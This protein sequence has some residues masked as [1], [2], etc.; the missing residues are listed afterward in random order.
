MAKPKIFV[1]RDQPGP[2]LT[3]LGNLY[4]VT[5]NPED[6][7]VSKEELIAAVKEVDGIIACVG[8]R[9]DGEVMDA[10]GGFLK[11][12][13][14]AIVGFDNVDLK[15]ATERGIYVTN[16]PGVL[17]E[18]VADLAF[19]L[20]LT[21]SRRIAEAD[22]FIRTGRW[23]GWGPKQFLGFDVHGKTLGILGLG[24]IG[25]AVAKRAKGFDM[26][27]LYFDVFRNTEMEK[28]LGLHFVPLNEVLSRSDFVSV[29]VPLIP[30]TKHMIST[31][32]LDL[33]K[34]SAFLINSSRG[35]VV[36]EK[37]LITAL[38]AGKIC[39]AGLDVWDPEPPSV[40][41]PLLTM[42]NVVTLPHIASASVETRTQMIEMAIDNLKAILNGRIPPNLVNKE[43]ISVRPLKVS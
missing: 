21:L 30:Q 40:D 12:V 9:I 24:R 31:N 18:T 2:S 39:G 25:L 23:R 10:S 6:R 8:D 37:A 32:E 27:V 4:D 26:T 11:A 22:R 17:T 43:V 14:N 29:H 16:T 5:I 36:D 28:K 35:P 34:E 3:K 20:L 7:P 38:K 13:C 33:M 1:T 41:N 42:D 19:G 15:A